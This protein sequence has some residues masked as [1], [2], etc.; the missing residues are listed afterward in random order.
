MRFFRWVDSTAAPFSMYGH[1]IPTIFHNTDKLIIW[2]MFKVW[3]FSTKIPYREFL[4]EIL[5]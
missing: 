4:H 5:K 3:K 2:N 1:E